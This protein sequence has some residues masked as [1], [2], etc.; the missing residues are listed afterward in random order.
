MNPPVV[1]VGGVVIRADRRVLIVRRGHP[2]GQGTWSLPGGKVHAG[3]A[4]RD[5]L[6]RELREETGLAVDIGMLIDVVEIIREGV[7]YVVI[8][9][10]CTPRGDPDKARAADD[11]AELRWV[12]EDEL[13]AANITD[14]VRRVVARAL[15]MPTCS[16]P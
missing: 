4:L 9:Y 2:P 3:E 8:D 7:H 14:E 16:S 12:S 10:V 11:A 15:Q 1:G 6:A 13:A 5:A